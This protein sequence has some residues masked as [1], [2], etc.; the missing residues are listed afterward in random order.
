MSR[1]SHVSDYLRALVELFEIIAADGLQINSPII[2]NNHVTLVLVN[3]YQ[4][5][6]HRVVIMVLQCYVSSTILPGSTD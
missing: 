3:K 4:G 6:Y 5:C 1:L 2:T